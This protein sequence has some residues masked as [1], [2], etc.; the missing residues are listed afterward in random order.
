ME[1]VTTQPPRVVGRDREIAAVDEFLTATRDGFAAV[2]LEG[3]AGIGKT[4]VWLEGVNAARD[5]GYRVLSARPAQSE[6]TFS[7]A[8]LGDL[9]E[10]A[11]G[12]VRSDLSEPQ[13][14]A[15]DVALLR[16]PA[17]R[18]APEQRAVAVAFLNLLR[19][20]ARAGPVVLAVDDVQ[21]LD[22]G[23]A[24][25]LEFA[26]R[27]LDREP[28]GLLATLRSSRGTGADLT[29]ALEPDRVRR[30]ALAPLSS[31]ALHHVLMSHL[32]ISMPRPMLLQLQEISAG[33]PFFA[34]EMARA[35]PQGELPA[36]PG[37][38]LPVPESLSALVRDRLADLS[39]G[40]REILLHVAAMA[41]PD[42]V[43]VRRGTPARP[44]ADIALRRAADAGVIVFDGDRLRFT[45]PLLASVLYTEASPSVRRRIHR[46]LAGTVTDPEEK[47]RHHALAS[48][49]PSTKVA[50]VLDDAARLARARGAPGRAAEL[51]ELAR[52]RTP[53]NQPSRRHQRMIEAADYHA[54]AG[55]TDRARSLL[56]QLRTVLP[57][58]P[59][60]AGLL[61][62]LGNLEMDRGDLTQAR[63]LLE[64]ALAQFGDETAL[65][66]DIHISLCWATSFMW[67]LSRATAHAHSAIALA[68]QAGDPSRLAEAMSALGRMD[69]LAGRATSDDIAA[70]ALELEGQSDDISI[71]LRPSAELGYQWMWAGQLD[72]A[73]SVLQDL[74]RLAV[75]GGVESSLPNTFFYLSIL[76][77]LAGNWEEA[78]QHAQD[79]Y[80][81]AQ[82]TGLG[83]IGALYQ[84]ALVD[85][86]LGRVDEARTAAQRSLEMA[87]TAGD[88][89]IIQDLG[90]LGFV[91]LSLGKPAEAQSHLGRAAAMMRERDVWTPAVLRI[92]PDHVEA[93]VFMGRTAEAEPFVERLEGRVKALDE[94]WA[95]PAGA[96][97]RGLLA[98]GW[99]D[100]SA[101]LPALERA[102]A[103]HEELGQPFELARSLMAQGS[104]LR[105]A[106]HKRP[107]RDSLER[108]TGIFERLGARTWA[109]LARSELA[110]IG[111][112]A[113]A[114]PAA[115][116]ATEERVASLAA[117]GLTNRE[118]ADRSFMSVKTVEANLSRI[119]RKLGIR[120]RTELARRMPAG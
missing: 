63:T 89:R 2:I 8:A 93:L 18:R 94:R 95:V 32:G 106:L 68:E 33:N 73:R 82:L 62:R 16:A 26:L 110:R 78:R 75:E 120:S 66:A 7:F 53:S 88:V 111:G 100:P 80:L 79:S 5:L 57:P 42:R 114:A 76:E 67:D 65:G 61:R 35:F 112:R 81:A 31:G 99:G 101:G 39:S 48:D 6:A 69:Y 84:R 45:H 92:V 64:E 55:N 1:R 47:A 74:H 40:D 77:W 108:A 58:G 12:E 37:H 119:Y 3:D 36:Q 118:I 34:L 97:C 85:A 14:E 23:S 38:V 59:E 102:V 44:N 83:E 105:R 28:V 10:E 17:R 103:G 109:G 29:N 27:R 41:R 71:D 72:R 113:P 98:L 19:T 115:L 21:W 56:E 24:S 117:E 116:S 11:L 91:D 90:V 60:R 51:A 52:D 86:H 107:A 50:E 104:A 96:R 87:E 22:G 70:R 15:L 49:A 4:A 20:L 9:A 54:A 25:V 30:V 43:S 13:Q 46:R